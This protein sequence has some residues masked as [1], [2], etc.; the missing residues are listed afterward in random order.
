MLIRFEWK[1][2]GKMLNYS[3]PLVFGSISG[4]LLAVFDR[5]V[6]NFMADQPD[7]GKYA[8]A[9]KFSSTIKLLVVT[10]IQ[11]AISPIVLKMMDQP[12]NKRF[13]SKIM[14]YFTFVV[15][16]CV[17][18]LSIFGLEIVKIFAYSR[19]YWVAHTIIPFL[20]FSVLFGMMKDTS[21]IG[22]TIT[23]RTGIIGIV[24]FFI[25]LI[26]LGLN[27]LLIP[28]YKI[29]GAA[30]STLASQVLYFIL[31][32]SLARRQYKI[33]YEYWKLAVM[34]GLAA[35]L[36]TVAWFIN[37]LNPIL[38]IIIKLILFGSFPFILYMIGFYEKIELKRLAGA[39]DK[40]K[41][42]SRWIEN[43]TEM[44]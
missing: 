6:L 16:I 19:E 27:I 40:W 44:Y 28:R 35:V 11:L 38:R 22:L 10:S 43:I 13:Y 39:W 8:L 29:M 14:T 20:S 18:G 25:A 7:V 32:N 12:D 15:T 3:L 37:P 21:M 34:V 26:N 36:I 33:P 5:F 41:K 1:I 30:L 17:L 9:F 24:I 2:L 23:R 31:I 42:P 4:V